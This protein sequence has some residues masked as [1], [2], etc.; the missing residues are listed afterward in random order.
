MNMHAPIPSLHREAHTLA[1]A[2]ASCT[3]VFDSAL[4]LRFQV[5][6]TT[7][8]RVFGGGTAC[9][10]FTDGFTRLALLVVCWWIPVTGVTGVTAEPAGPGCE[11]GRVTRSVVGAMDVSVASTRAS[12]LTVGNRRTTRDELNLI[13]ENDV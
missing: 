12:A 1:D 13:T 5:S 6:V 10:P 4:A 8:R 7:S 3:Y 11:C 9:P 2:C